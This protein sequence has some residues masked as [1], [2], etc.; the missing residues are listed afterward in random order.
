MVYKSKISDIYRSD[1]EINSKI[2][3][4]SEMSET[5]SKNL[6]NIE[7]HESHFDKL[8]MTGIRH[9]E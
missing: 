8:S 4:H 1:R 5:K 9:P 3:R 6:E 2:N 7:A